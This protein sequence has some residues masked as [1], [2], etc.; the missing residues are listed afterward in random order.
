MDR[1]EKAIDNLLIG[2]YGEINSR[3]QQVSCDIE[4]KGTN[5]KGYCYSLRVDANGELRLK[6]LVEFIDT[7]LVDY[8]IPKKD[9]DEA[10]NYFNNTGSASKVLALKK[11][12]KTLFTDLEKTGEGGETLLYILVLEYLKIPQLISKMTLKTS[13]QVH[14]QGADGIHVKFDNEKGKLNLFW[15]ESKMYKK[16]S[17]AMDNCL[18]CVKDFSLDPQSAESV[19]QGDLEL[20]T[21]NLNANVKMTF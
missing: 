9:I 18:S 10:R 2:S 6:D 5:S 15:G 20:I 11:R 13:G 7:K 3:L 21:S 12:A 4:I 17:T 1:I 19:Q 8:A 14:Y 16:M